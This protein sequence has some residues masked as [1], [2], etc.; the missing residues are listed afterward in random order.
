MRVSARDQ[1]VKRQPVV[2]H[3]KHFRIG[4]CSSVAC[5]AVALPCRNMDAR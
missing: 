2:R 1:F 5:R 4:G 3:H